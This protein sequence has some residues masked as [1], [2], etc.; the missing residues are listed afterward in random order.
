M[1]SAPAIRRVQSALAIA[2]ALLGL[3][4]QCG[5][6]TVQ[7]AVA[8][9]FAEPL[10]MIA[11][12]FEQQTSHTV[13]ASAGAS[14]RFYAQIR[15]GAPF[16]LFLSA[17]QETV[18]RLEADGLVLPGSRF[19]YAVGRLVLW[20]ARPGV[21]DPRRDVLQRG[22]FDRLAIA[23]PELAPY[24]RA[25]RE[26]LIRLGLEQRLAPRLVLGESI[27]QAYA[28]VASGNAPLGFVA[29]SQVYRDGVM[30]RGSAWVVPATL[31]S[32]IRQDAVLL[33]HARGNAAASALMR[34]LRTAQAQDVLRAFGYEHDGG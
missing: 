34:Y 27:G 8:A 32:P 5:A 25:A 24:G 26:V 1:N 9:N 30:S 22:A 20:S 16:D 10:R 6:A 31:H 19:T 14:G 11:R 28:F 18:A 23:A 29:L 2:A 13:A 21:V 15:N 33:L 12:S 4:G 17:D 7:V 3:P